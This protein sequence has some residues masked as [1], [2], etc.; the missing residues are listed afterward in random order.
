MIRFSLF[1]FYIFLSI[2][3][4]IYWNFVRRRINLIHRGSESEPRSPQSSRSQR[5]GVPRGLRIS[6]SWTVSRIRSPAWPPRVDVVDN[7]D[8]LELHEASE[9]WFHQL[10]R[11]FGAPRDLGTS[12]SLTVSRIRRLRKPQ[13]PADFKS[14]QFEKLSICPEMD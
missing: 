14:S 11:G 2:C 4:S 9:P 6:I 7:F 12:I 5:F 1:C 13:K 3:L 8:D 10:F